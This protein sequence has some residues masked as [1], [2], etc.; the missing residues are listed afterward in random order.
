LTS[1]SYHFPWAISSLVAWCLFCTV[2]ERSM[3]INQSTRDYFDVGDRVDLA[4]EEKLKRY[5]ELAD[6]HLQAAA[7]A[8]FRDAALTHLEE[9]MIEYIEST[10]FDELL[11]RII[12]A[13]ERSDMQELLIERTRARV[14]SW[15]ADEHAAAR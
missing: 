12:R 7:F 6:D 11:V 14:R 10:E 5:R 4:Y 13:E 15:A 8:E 3:A 9:A 2:T 1:L